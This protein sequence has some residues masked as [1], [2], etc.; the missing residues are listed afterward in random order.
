MTNNNPYL[1]S[2]LVDSAKAVQTLVKR[3][4]PSVY[5]T[6]TD[7]DRFTFRE[8]VVHLADWEPILLGR[9][10]HAVAHPGSTVENIDEGERAMTQNYAAQD[11]VQA[12][13]SF[14]RLRHETVAWLK[15]LQPEDWN[16]LTHHDLRGTMSVYDWANLLLGHDAYHLRHFL[17]FPSNYPKL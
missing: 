2:G 12:A 7:P 13:E 8:G 10:K 4:D 16:A 15:S 6:K 9:M 14:V 5:D 17:D 3:A 11:P 1:L